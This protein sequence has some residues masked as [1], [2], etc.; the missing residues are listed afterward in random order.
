MR[1]SKPLEW[2]QVN[3]LQ[4]KQP[5][6]DNDM[7]DSD[8]VARGGYSMIQEVY[9]WVGRDVAMIVLYLCKGKFSASSFSD[10]ILWQADITDE[11][12]SRAMCDMECALEEIELMLTSQRG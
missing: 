9:S 12:A 7:S 4:T 2:R 6:K 5:S 1:V 10:G 11:Q 8:F 3:V